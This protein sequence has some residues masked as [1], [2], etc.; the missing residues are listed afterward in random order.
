[1]V[2]EKNVFVRCDRI[3]LD[4]TIV[5]RAY[6]HKYALDGWGLSLRDEKDLFVSAR[7]SAK[8]FAVRRFYYLDGISGGTDSEQ[9]FLLKS[10][11]L[12]KREGQYFRTD[13]PQIFSGVVCAIF[14]DCIL[15]SG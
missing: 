8:C 5:A 1:M 13:L 4:R 3:W 6:S 15:F 11:G 12:F 10:L 2:Y 9:T 7:G 14:A